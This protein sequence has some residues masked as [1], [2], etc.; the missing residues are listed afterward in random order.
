MSKDYT[1]EQLKW[2]ADNYYNAAW[3]EIFLHFPN[4]NKKYIHQ[5][6]SK[7]GI[8]RNKHNPRVEN[9]NDIIGDQYGRLTVISYAGY[10]SQGRHM[11]LCKCSCGN[12]KEIVRYSL[13]KGITKSCGCL[14]NE[15]LAILNKNATNSEKNHIRN[16][17]RHIKSSAKTRG[18]EFNLSYDDIKSLVNQSCYYCGLENSNIDKGRCQNTE[19]GLFYY[20]GID[21]IDSNKGYVK[22]N[23]VPC[24]KFCNIAKNTMSQ[25]EFYNWIQRIHN[26]YTKDKIVEK[27]E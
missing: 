18:Y 9:V 23:V 11:Y 13:I 7:N 2:L 27:V 21:R 24:C 25:Y 5:L 1:D 26:Y 20:N 15:Q 8:K 12:Y 16:I 14:H 4:K 6:A 17:R 19:Y 10:G 3:E 22:G